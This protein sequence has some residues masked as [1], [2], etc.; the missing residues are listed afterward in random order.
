MIHTDLSPPVIHMHPR[1]AT[2]RA[3]HRTY[4][5]V[6]IESD[7]PVHFQWTRNSVALQDGDGVLGSNTRRLR[8]EGIDRH[9]VGDYSCI[10]TNEAGGVVTRP[11]SLTIVDGISRRPS[12]RVGHPPEDPL[13]E[14]R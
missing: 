8:V 3:G 13:T 12:S 7:S 6:S 4:F 2:V 5:K 1:P 10:I 14:V 9:K 11:A